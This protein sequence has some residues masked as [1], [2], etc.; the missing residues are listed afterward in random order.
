MRLQRAYTVPK[1]QDVQNEDRFASSDLAHALSDGASISYDSALW[2]QILC[3]H[4]VE[5]PRLTKEW[6]TGCI[7]KFSAHHER[8]SLPWHKE[9]AF[10]RGSFASL[11]G[12]TFA[13]AAIQIDAIG[14]SI[15]ALC[16]GT[17]RIDSFPYKTPEQFDQ[18][19]MLLCTDAAKNPFFNGGDLSGESV[20]NW[21]LEGLRVTSLALH[22]GRAW[23]VAAFVARRACD[24]PAAFT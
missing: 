15:A 2:A 4:Y 3:A 13:N 9:A 21:L 8:A 22:D 14:D 10:D 6:L 20:C 23:A 24:L 19:P 16:N 1:A 17:T 18:E 5:N 7:S 12:I 11:L